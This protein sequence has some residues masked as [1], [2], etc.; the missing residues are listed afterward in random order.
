MTARL[1]GLL[2]GVRRRPLPAL[3]GLAVLVLLVAAAGFCGWSRHQLGAAEQ[4]IQRY[5]LHQAHQH[6]ERSRAAWPWNARAHF[7]AA[8]T[9]RRLDDHATAERLLTD[10]EQA[11]GETT[12]TRLEW[13]LLGVQQGD[14]AGEERNLQLRV[15]REHADTDLILEA[16]AK[17]YMNTFRWSDLVN[18]A[19]IWLERRPR[20]PS[21]LALRARGL[22]GLRRPEEALAFYQQ[23]VD[24]APGADDTRLGLAEMLNRLGRPREAVYHYEVLRQKQPAG[25]AVLLGLARCR[26]DACEPEPARQLLDELLAKQPDHV[27]GLV[28]RGR[29][30]L[31]RKQ[32]A[33]AET[34]LRRATA[35][36]PWHREAHQLLRSCLEE[37][38]KS[39]EVGPCQERLRQIQAEE[40]AAALLRLRLRGAARDPDV[41]C[42]LGLWCLRNG[43]EQAGIRWLC[44]ALLVGPDHRPTHA[45]LADYFERTGQPRRA[46]LHRALTR[47][48][49]T[50]LNP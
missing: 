44:T 5:D 24:R 18:C 6:L 38:G 39:A 9:A 45:E 40:R 22:E 13:L 4:A 20:H 11:E 14:Y 15:D 17:G 8:Q 48:S 28:E 10:Y 12:Q 41:R 33:E 34:D 46:A 49:N 50:G 47:S 30:A 7:L 43:Q 26:F 3:G 42:E 23:A 31:H 19:D 29:L 21:A 27:A 2:R 25:A 37:S 35:L 32:L 1:T 16:L 36:A